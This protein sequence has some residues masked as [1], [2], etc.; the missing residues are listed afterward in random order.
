MPTPKSPLAASESAPGRSL[1]GYR[2]KVSTADRRMEWLPQ[3]TAVATARGSY[4]YVGSAVGGELLAIVA[5]T[6]RVRWRV[7]IDAIA[8]APV[9]RGDLLYVGTGNGEV[10]CVD[11]LTGEVKWRFVSNGPIAEA[12]VVADT[13]VI[14][15]NETD[16]VT[17]LDALTGEFKWQ[18]KNETGSADSLLRGHAGLAA[19]DQFVYTGF[20]NATV[21]ALR[22][23]SGSVSWSSRLSVK[24]QKYVDVD[25]TPVLLGNRLYVASGAGGV[26]ALDRATGLTVWSQALGDKDG[27]GLSELTTDGTNLYVSAATDGVFALDLEGNVLWQQAVAGGGD[28]SMPLLLAD[29]VLVSYA[30]FGLL[31]LR[32]DSGDLVQYFDPGGGI[33]ASP[34]LG[35]GASLYVMSNRGTLFSMTLDE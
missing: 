35:A 5:A 30:N 3:E 19:D 11:T 33:S 12:P 25:S 20:S 28:P 23:A 17:A 14:F 2:W 27:V 16:R 29:Y 31:A 1:F 24:Q 13:L 26:F 21:V 22:I 10:V 6:G 7:D 8:S 18:Y 34:S 4:V 9:I 32:K 15:A